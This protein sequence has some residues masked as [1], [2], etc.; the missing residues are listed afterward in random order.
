MIKGLLAQWHKIAP[1]IILDAVDSLFQTGIVESGYA[2]GVSERE[3]MF[4][5]H[6][7][8]IALAHSEGK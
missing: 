6:K 2:K 4:E 3:I 8:E 1:V 5:R 7:E